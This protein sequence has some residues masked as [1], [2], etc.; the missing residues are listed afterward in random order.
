MLTCMQPHY[1]NE[2]SALTQY[3]RLHTGTKYPIYKY[4]LYQ[5]LGVGRTANWKMF[6]EADQSFK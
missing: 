1:I 3:K 4:M 2:H 6:K 5:A